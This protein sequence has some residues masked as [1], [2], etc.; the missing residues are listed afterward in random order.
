MCTLYS[1]YTKL[2]SQHVKK[3][4]GNIR[5]VLTLSIL[6]KKKNTGTT[7]WIENNIEGGLDNGRCF[8]QVWGG[9][10]DGQIVSIQGGM[11][12][13]RQILGDVQK[14]SR[15]HKARGQSQGHEKNP[16]PR[17][18]FRGQ[19]LSRPRTGMLEAKAKDQEHSRKC[20]QKKRSSIKFFRQSPI[21]SR[22][23]NF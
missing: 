6:K 15:K 12:T 16:R 14:W 10:P 22:S 18:A 23:Q 11:S 1:V 19:T 20:S 5:I 4:Q 21:Y 2:N 7:D 8:E 9:G 17:T 13:P 3:M